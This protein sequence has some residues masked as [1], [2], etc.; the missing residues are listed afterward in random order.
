MPARSTPNSA[1]G[2]CRILGIMSATRR[3]ALEPGFLLQ[4]GCEGAAE[5]IELRIAQRRAHVG[6]GG[7]VPVGGARLLENIPQ[8]GIL[9]RI[10][11]R[12][13]SGGILLQPIAIH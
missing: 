12:R 6:K 5:F 10:D 9:I 13:H 7:R 8:R 11:V 1:M 4:P 3:P 2:Y